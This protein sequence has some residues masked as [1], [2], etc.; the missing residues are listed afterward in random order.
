MKFV[1][2]IL[3]FVF[4][5]VACQA[6]ISLPARD[7]IKANGAIFHFEEPDLYDFGNITEG[8]SVTHEFIFTNVGARPLTITDAMASCGC[9]T[10]IWPKEPVMPGKQGKITVTYHSAGHAGPFIK[11][12]FI[13]SNAITPGQSYVL[14]IKGNVI[15]RSTDKNGQ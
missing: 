14:H 5:A 4:T 10:P 8:K 12:I 15:P 13:S 11:N 9:T 6:Q 3:L 2:N 7:S 1:Y